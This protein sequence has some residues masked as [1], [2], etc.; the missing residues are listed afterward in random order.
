MID[1]FGPWSSALGDGPSNHLDTF[2]KR[3]LTLLAPTRTTRRTLRPRDWWSLGLA[4]VAVLIV[5]TLHL[6]FAQDGPA[7]GPVDA[8]KIYARANFNQ[9]G[10]QDKAKSGLFSIDPVTAK[11]QKLADDSF[12][13]V[14]VAPDRRTI[15]LSKSGWSGPGRPVDGAG[16]WTINANGAGVKRKIADAGGTLCW[17]PDSE[18]LIVTRGITPIIDGREVKLHETWRLKADGSEATQLAIPASEEVDDWSPDGQWVVTVSDRQTPKFPNYQLY[19]M[20]LDGTNERLI[21]DGTGGNVY[22]RFSPDGK[23]VAYL[24][25]NNTGSSIRVVNTDGTNRRVLVEETDKSHPDHLAWSPDGRSI[26]FR[27]QVPQ[28]DPEDGHKF[29][30]VEKTNPKFV[31]I[32]TNGKN[33]RVLDTPSARW[34]EEPDWK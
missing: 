20:H 1:R 28:F 24:Y 5:P 26:V 16:I 14:R 18:S 21:S 30:E 4:A 19:V 25:F 33:R 15:A 27:S 32:D 9:P 10:E 34:L 23:Q 2:W 17:S 11:T 8:N 7:S 3:R 6:A 29:Y 13:N 12:F 31:I 22:P